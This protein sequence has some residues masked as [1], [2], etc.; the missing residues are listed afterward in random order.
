M[1]EIIEYDDQYAGVFKELNLEWLDHYN[2]TEDHD[3]QILDKPRELVLDGGGSIFLARDNDRVVGTAGI[4]NEGDHVYELIKMCVA[5]SH[6]GRGISRML[7]DKCL[8]TA[9]L[10]GA[11]KIFLYSNSQLTIAIGLYKK[12]GFVHVDASNSPLAS[13]DVKM[14]LVL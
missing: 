14:E 9:R 12:Y 2:V 1:I 3:L 10:K 11:R 6:Q 13:A 8:E 7:I 4:S 5:K